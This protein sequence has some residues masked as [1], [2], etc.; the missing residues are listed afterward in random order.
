MQNIKNRLDRDSVSLLL[1]RAGYEIDRHCKFMLREE[2]TP[3]AVINTDG[4]VHDYGDDFHGDVFDVLMKY[5]GM[6]FP[7]AKEFVQNTLGITGSLET[8]FVPVKRKS[9]PTEITDERYKEIVKEV[10][11][12]DKNIQTFADATYRTEALAIA[13]M[14][15]YKSADNASLKLFREFSTFDGSTIVIKIRDYNGRLIS[16]KRRRYN[17]SKW[18]TAARTHPNK[19]CLLNIRDDSPIYVIEGM[20]DFLTAVL[21][22]VNVL[23]IPTV[24]YK[25][26]T[27]HEISLL[28]GKDVYFLP[29]LKI[30]DLNGVKAMQR[31]KEQ[32][33]M[34]AKNTKMV[35][36][37]KFLKENDIEADEKVDL[38]EAV[39]L[40]IDKDKGFK[41][42]LQYFCD[43]GIYREG[44]IL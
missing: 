35:N 20:H 2:R 19:Q 44:E 28:K 26:F 8:V 41:G 24:N 31:L 39:E 30:G 7:D 5:K 40:W 33:Q 9:L 36:L 17:G 12:F 10:C 16:F 42:Y 43:A 22:G 15:V 6:T 13:P 29:D 34:T 1:E 3:S 23:A 32:V 21:L 25:K 18:V 4:T 14:W 11:R 27:D 38:S 37:R